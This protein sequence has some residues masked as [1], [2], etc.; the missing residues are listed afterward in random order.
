M[1]E[2]NSFIIGNCPAPNTMSI[3]QPV[4]QG[5]IRSLKVH[6]QGTVVHFLC[7]LCTALEKNEPYSKTSILQAAKLLS[8]SLE[9]ATKDTVIYCFKKAG[10]N[11]DVKQVVIADSDDP[12]K[13]LHE[14]LNNL[15]SRSING[16][17]RC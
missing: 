6:Y 9:S 7:F 4:D 14:N 17:R 11:S 8:D 1:D 3:L 5:V 13:D 2:K 15:I 16:A 10:I 12:Y